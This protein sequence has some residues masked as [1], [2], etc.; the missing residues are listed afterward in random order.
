MAAGL[1]LPLVDT[2]PLRRR[3]AALAENR[4]GTYRMLDP[5]G[6]VIYVGKAKRIRARLL[7]YFRARYPD[8]KAARILAAAA[9]VAWDYAP[10]EFGAHL[11][12]LR[13]IRRHRPR[14]NV[15]MNR[16]GTV[17]FVKLSRGPAPKIYV[18]RA[19]GDEPVAHYGPFRS[20]GQLRESV[21]VL[22]LE[23]GLRDCALDMPVVYAE[24]GDLFTAP[25]R[26]A[27]LRYE[28]G[29]C[30][31]PCGG[32][33]TQAAYEDRVGQAMAFLEGRGMAPLDRVVDAMTR[34]SEDAAFEA[35]ARLRDR[36]EALEWLFAAGSRIRAAIDALSFVYVDPGTYGDDR[37]YVIRRATVRASAPAPHTPI[38]RTAF[39]A[40]V[41]E[42][43]GPEPASGALPPDAI[44]EMVLLLSW[45]RRH[46]AALRRTMPLEEWVVQGGE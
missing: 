28:L 17:A 40:L 15:Q 8:D 41:A 11:A 37:A 38:E 27:C 16:L 43:A 9:D 44:D 31:G 33:V 2:A 3:V 24:Q 7:S 34:A 35:A 36:F 46:P 6:H 22:N 4:P 39:R 23:L 21:R 42:H 19:G 30:L 25:R 13:L 45:F 20:A 32:F 26:A 10:S 14:F 18:G 5:A 29:S 12:E 1:A